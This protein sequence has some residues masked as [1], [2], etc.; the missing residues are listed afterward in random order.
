[1]LPLYS[2]KVLVAWAIATIAAFVIAG[3]AHAA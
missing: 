2:G 3:T 1:M